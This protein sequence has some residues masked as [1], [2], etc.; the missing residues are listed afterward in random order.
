[1]NSIPVNLDGREGQGS[2]VADAK[3]KILQVIKDALL[4]WR[5]PNGE[6]IVS[7]VWTNEEAF[8]GPLK[9]SAPDLVVGY[10]AGFR[11]SSQ[12]GL[13][14]WERDAFPQNQDHRG[15]DYGIDP[16]LVQGVVFTNSEVIPPTRPSYEHV[17][18]WSWDVPSIG[19]QDLLVR[20]LRQPKMRLKSWKRG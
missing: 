16:S 20:L 12:T 13:G 1:L 18:D 10:N 2:L 6:A 9:E 5:G 14:G 8:E 15:A 4:A 17:P 11:A 19:S 3:P 7:N